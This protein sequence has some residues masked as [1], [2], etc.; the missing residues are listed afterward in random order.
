MGVTLVTW[1]M[2]PGEE[3]IV[4]RRLKEILESARR[5]AKLRPKRTDLELS[6]GFGM[7]N[8]IDEWDADTDGLVPQ[9][10]GRVTG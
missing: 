7:D 9:Y 3:K 6:A 5:T 4:A 10:P 1:M 8:P 2:V